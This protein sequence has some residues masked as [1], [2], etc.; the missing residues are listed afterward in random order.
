MLTWKKLL[1]DERFGDIYKK[2]SIGTVQNKPDLL[3]DHQFRLP[4]ERDH[5]RVL[6]C[7]PFRRLGDKT[8]VF[9]LESIESVRTRLT[10][11]YEVANLARS[12]GSEIAIKFRDQFKAEGLDVEDINRQLPAILAAVG[13]AHDIGNP[14]FGHQGENAIRAWFA[15]NQD[16]L[17]ASEGDCEKA[18]DINSLTK[19]HKKDFLHFEGNAQGLRV[20]SKLLVLG[21][22]LGLNLTLGTLSSL[23][24]Y[25]GP[26][27]ELDKDVKS[28]K[29]VGYFT[30]EA[31]LVK[32]VR[33][34]TG[35]S[36]NTRH[37]L[38]LIMEACDDIAYSVIDVED[39]I[40]K[41]L[42]SFNDLVEWLERYNQKLATDLNTPKDAR[43]ADP[44]ITYLCESAKKAHEDLATHNLQPSE[45]NEVATQRFRVNAIHIMVCAVV[46]AFEQNYESIMGD[47]FNSDLTSCS[48]AS[49]LYE[50]LKG[51]AAQ[52]AFSNKSVLQLEL[53]GYNVINELMDFLWMGISQREDYNELGSRRS[54]PFASYVYSR[55]S[56]NYKRLFEGTVKQYHQ[57]EDL[58][59][60]YREMLLLTDMISGMTDRFCMDLHSELKQHYVEMQPTAS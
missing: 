7:S 11:S 33:K 43:S 13:L 1:C 35:L 45:L 16:N 8:Q 54:N 2:Q 23:M 56:K 21:D 25:I 28:R 60:R 3:S 22:D 51:F 19:Q 5:D 15:R 50:A 58:P 41:S 52:N 10:H 49:H 20:L 12:I 26:S 34:H 48:Q 55:I 17:F 42:V 57:G 46:D 39:S 36:G 14:P 31:K 47:R 27:N 40:K 24:K 44:I 9:P 6:F 30:A 32:Q 38:A 37:P 53:N 4:Q 18:K 59:V 29:K